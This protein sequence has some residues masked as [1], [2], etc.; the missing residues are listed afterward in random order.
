MNRAVIYAHF[1]STK[2]REES[3]EGQIREYTSFAEYRGFKIVETYIDRAISDHRPDFKKII[4]DS[5]GN[6]FDYVLVYQLDRFARNRYDSAV[7]KNKLKK[8]SVRMLSAR[9]NIT[10]DASVIILE[11]VLE[12]MAE[13]YSVELAQKVRRGMT[14]SALACKALAHMPLDYTK[15]AEGHIHL[16][17]QKIPIVKMI[18]DRYI[19]NDK[20]GYIITAANEKCYLHRHIPL[21]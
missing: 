14:D 7:Y 5:R 20:I 17:E 15:D 6:K 4:A 10:D 2:Q 3:I 12:G 11:S 13:Y 18:F 21:E 9:K 16:N 1:L 19:K 8:N